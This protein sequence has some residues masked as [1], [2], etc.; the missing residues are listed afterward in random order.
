[1]IEH[2]EKWGISKIK[3]E[4]RASREKM[5]TTKGV[6]GDYHMLPFQPC[7]ARTVKLIYRSRL[8]LSIQ[9]AENSRF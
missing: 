6:I 2:I 8:R 9:R 7:A 1:M 5:Y 3:K 4:R